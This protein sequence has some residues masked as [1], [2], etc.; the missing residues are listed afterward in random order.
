M[1]ANSRRDPGSAICWIIRST[2][3]YRP[4]RIKKA[5]QSPVTRKTS[6]SGGKI[7]RFARRERGYG[8][9]KPGRRSGAR[10]GRGQTEPGNEGTT[11][12]QES[13]HPASRRHSVSV[14]GSYRSWEMYFLGLT[15]LLSSDTSKCTWEPVERPV[16]PN[17]AM[18]CPFSTQSPIRTRF[19][20]LCA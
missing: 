19:F 6:A 14:S 3:I 9:R 11:P 12:R 17:K 15:G 16:D 4:L 5:A 8:K 2:V 20:L 18:D 13:R 1:R 10:S 7:W